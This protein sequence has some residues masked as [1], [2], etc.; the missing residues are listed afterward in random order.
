MDIIEPIKIYCKEDFEDLKLFDA[1]IYN[2]DRHLGNF[3]MIVDNN[4]KILLPEPI[5]DNE[6][7]MI[8][9]L[10]EYKLKDISKAMNNKISFFD[11]SLNEQL[12]LFTKERHIP[13]L[14]KLSKFDFIKH[15]EFNLKDSFLEQIN[16][17]IQN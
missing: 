13:N 10:T 15:K 12:R 7:S 9:I 5:F 3:E 17:Y 16:K 4:T 14:E 1:L 11:F 6:L 8:N 2:T